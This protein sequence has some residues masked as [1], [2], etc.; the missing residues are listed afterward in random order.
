M[1]VAAAQR[2][3]R[4]CRTGA[5][6]ARMAAPAP[7]AGGVA[8]KVRVVRLNPQRG[9]ARGRA[10]VSAKAVDA[11]LRYLQRDGVTKDG[12]KGQVYS[13]ERDVEDG[14]AF[15][16]RGRRTATS[17]ASSSRPRTGPNSPTR[18]RP[19]AV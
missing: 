19:P 15:V 1:R 8:V 18:A 10:F 2:S 11:H 16:E 9:V 17:S 4:H 5:P 14:E 7:G 3:R 12:E 6:G 13:A